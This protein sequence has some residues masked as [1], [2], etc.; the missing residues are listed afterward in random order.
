MKKMVLVTMI[1]LSALLGH[2]TFAEDG[3]AEGTS[4]EDSLSSAI[5]QAPSF[6]NLL[7]AF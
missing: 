6:G 3:T 7:I 2:Q 1:V 5:S 4:V